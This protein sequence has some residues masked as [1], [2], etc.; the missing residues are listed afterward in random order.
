MERLVEAILFSSAML[1]PLM[2]VWAI[3]GLYT[4]KSG[5][6]CPLT[7]MLYFAVMLF[8]AGFT[9]R[10]VMTDDSGCWL[11]HTASLGVMIVAGVL[12]KPSGFSATDSPLLAE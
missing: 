5:C 7:E 3:F 12:R 9:V 11:M 1:V 6:Q 10:T 8:V 2:T 4:V